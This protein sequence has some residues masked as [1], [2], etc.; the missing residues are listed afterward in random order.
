MIGLFG[1]T[2]NPIHWGHIRTASELKQVL[3]IE[4][5]VLV[6]SGF[7]PHRDAP[8]VDPPTRLAMVEAAVKNQPGLSVD[9]RELRREGPSYT[10]DTLDEIRQQYNDAPICLIVGADAFLQFDTWHRWRRIFDL[11]HIVVVSR[12]GWPLADLTDKISKQ[13]QNVVLPRRIADFQQL[14]LHPAGLVLMQKV[15]ELDI[16]SSQI[17]AKIA[18]GE[19][20]KELV[21]EAVLEII[22]E[23][24]LYKPNVFEA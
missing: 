7:P 3:D 21:P 24:G 13:L 4:Q 14:G 16:S 9:S 17:R 12:P 8:S 2:F 5:M 19:S 6:P 1:G 22:R 18:K 20:I 15:V 10:V 11:A 23:N